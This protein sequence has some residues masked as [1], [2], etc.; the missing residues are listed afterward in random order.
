MLKKLGDDVIQVPLT[1]S[2]KASGVVTK[3]SSLSNDKLKKKSPDDTQ[4]L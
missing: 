3:N 1:A 4:N 2:M